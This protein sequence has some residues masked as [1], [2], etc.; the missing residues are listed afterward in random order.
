MDGSQSHKS[1]NYSPIISKE[2]LIAMY[3]GGYV[4]PIMH[5]VSEFDSPRGHIQSFSKHSRHNDS[6]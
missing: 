2:E 3:M 1:I 5:G 6:Q 4:P